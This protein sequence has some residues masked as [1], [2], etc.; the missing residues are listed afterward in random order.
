MPESALDVLARTAGG[1]LSS[2]VVAL[3]SVRQRTK[4]LHPDGVLRR[5]TVTRNGSPTRTG[6]PWLDLAGTDAAL[7]RLSRGVGLPSP[8]PD[9]HGLALRLERDGNPAD[10]LFADTGVGPLT[11]YLLIPRRSATSHTL[12][13][14]LPYRSPRGPMLLA[15]R[16]ESEHRFELLRASAIGGWTSF[17]SIDLGEP[18][19]DDTRI[20]FDPVLNVLPGLEQY[21]WVKRLREPAYW[22]AR[23][24][25]HRERDT[26][27][28]PVPAA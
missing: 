1:L 12:T 6:V 7:V 22:S 28:P 20:S 14:L 21:D 4:P 2:G 11:R 25:S 3:G 23:R 16:P 10:V 5:A 19:G 17:G 26:A 9:V 15:A 27:R 18:L 24:R 13:T 8:L